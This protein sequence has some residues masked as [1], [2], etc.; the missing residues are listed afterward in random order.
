MTSSSRV[1]TE[2]GADRTHGRMKKKPHVGHRKP[3]DRADVA[4]A[5]ATLK[6]ELDDLALIAGQG[7]DDV[8]HMAERLALVVPFIEV[9][10]HG[11]IDVAE[12]LA[13][14]GPPACVERQVAADGEQP[15]REMLAESFRI[16]TAQTEEGLLDHVPSRL[17]VAQQPLRVADQPAFVQLQCVGDP[18]G[19]RRPA[20]WL[21][22]R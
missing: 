17:E 6:P 3:G 11:H 15:R 7:V 20:H 14:G 16:L 1:H 13:P 4:V 2:M 12:R 9:A 22:S 5:E 8:E 10:G 19:F 21:Y 18:G